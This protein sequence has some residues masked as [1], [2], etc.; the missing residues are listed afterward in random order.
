MKSLINRIALWYWESQASHLAWRLDNLR[1]EE[2]AIR[3]SIPTVLK[4]NERDQEEV[5]RRLARAESHCVM[6]A[7]PVNHDAIT[8]P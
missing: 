7:Q 2:K 8:H 1:A 3:K 6:H 5:S 4:A